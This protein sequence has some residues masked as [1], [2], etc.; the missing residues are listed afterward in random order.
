MVTFQE[1]R[2]QS[3]SQPPHRPMGTGALA[4]PLRGT[5]RYEEKRDQGKRVIIHTINHQ[6]KKQKPICEA[7]RQP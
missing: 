7:T 2:H 4:L 3:L 1:K 5:V 6:I